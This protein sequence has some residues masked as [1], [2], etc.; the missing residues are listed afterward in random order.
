MAD[1]GDARHARQLWG[2]NENLMYQV[3]DNRRKTVD[4]PSYE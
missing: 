3:S 2:M 4:E 1:G